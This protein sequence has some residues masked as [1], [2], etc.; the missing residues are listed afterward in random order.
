MLCCHCLVHKPERI[1]IMHFSLCSCSCMLTFYKKS[2][3]D[4]WQCD[5]SAGGPEGKT[6]GL[7][8]LA[9]EMTQSLGSHNQLWCLAEGKMGQPDLLK[10]QQWERQVYARVC[11]RG[12]SSWGSPRVQTLYDSRGLWRYM[13]KLCIAHRGVQPWLLGRMGLKA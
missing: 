3:T 2:T 5:K 12:G 7:A 10:W 11:Q 9:A 13:Q 8:N 6:R 4:V 1:V